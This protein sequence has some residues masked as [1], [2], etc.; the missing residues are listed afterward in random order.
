LEVR[1]A[2]FGYQRAKIFGVKLCDEEKV[3]RCDECT[4]VTVDFM[5]GLIYADSVRASKT[6][7]FP[8]H[9]VEIPRWATL[10]L[11]LMQTPLLQEWGTASLNCRPECFALYSPRSHANLR[12]E[13]KGG[14]AECRH[15]FS[16]IRD[17]L[18]VSS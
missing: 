2:I 12:W 8:R 13:D 3:E 18:P 16:A 11:Q 7:F 4:A 17:R 5:D 15:T 10:W 6:G 9:V 1:F 14:E